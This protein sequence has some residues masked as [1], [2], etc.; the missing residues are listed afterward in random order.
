MFR[1]SVVRD[2]EGILQA[3]Q[4]L[5]ERHSLQC[6]ILLTACEKAAICRMPAKSKAGNP[7]EDDIVQDPGNDNIHWTVAMANT[8]GKLYVKLLL[9]SETL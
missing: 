7:G 5:L 2:H 6:D 4:E 1:G 9:V 3:S 8:I